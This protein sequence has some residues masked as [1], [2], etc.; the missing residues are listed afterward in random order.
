VACPKRCAEQTGENLSYRKSNLDKSN[1]S[2]FK[3]DNTRATL[4]SIELSKGSVRGLGLFKA[5]LE[6]P[7]TAFAGS[8]GSGK[9]TML[10]LAA[11]AFHNTKSGFTPP[12]RNQTYYTFKDFF[13]QSDDETPI[14]GVNVRYGIRY[15]KWSGKVSEGLKFQTRSKRKGGRWND[16]HTR[17]K[18]NVI[19][20]GVQRVV[21]HF[22][23]SVSKSYRSRF[24]PGNLSEA[25]RKKIAKIAGRIIGKT[26]D[27]FDSYHH[28]KYSLPKVNSSG[29]SYSGFNMGAGE[30]AIFEI[31]TAIFRSGAGSLIVIDEIELGLHEK[32]QRRLIEQLKELCKELK[33]QIICSTH[34][35]AV[36]S[37]LP[38]EARFFIEGS[39][40]STVLTKG[41]S[42]EFACGKMGKPDAEELDVFVEDENA[43][44]I[45]AQ[46]L[47]LA[48]RKR[49]RIT[50]I[51][52][53]SAVLRQLA[54][55]SME[56][57]DNCICILDGDQSGDLARA[58][59][60]VVDGTEASTAEQKEAMKF[61]AT[62][63]I[64]YLPGDTWP[65]KWLLDTAI[66]T[67]ENDPIGGPSTTSTAWGLDNDDQVLE[68]L[69]EA[70]QADKH[71]E[72]YEL[73]EAVQLEPDRVREDVCRLILLAEPAKFADLIAAIEDKL[74]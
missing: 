34:S 5:E 18:R 69:K 55:R 10:A 31:L 44:A 24:K 53:H 27:D 13:V 3:K 64:H 43:A 46:M 41:I 19:Y 29:I 47:P 74:P 59:N 28:S 21:P 71:N 30:S 61:W 16:Y 57:V 49:C 11:C 4:A 36:L 63:R 45:V 73:A 37:S 48:S 32:A 42:A 58:I 60:K 66:E 72:F 2:W 23:R 38:P 17:V 70:S 15:N 62:P 1:I 14:Q 6:F 40:T 20:F 12:L 51:G 9:S 22:E 50:A 68:L 65:E 67:L 39:G 35:F 8:N 25:N 7:I 26:Y 56:K 33:C 54:S 52:S